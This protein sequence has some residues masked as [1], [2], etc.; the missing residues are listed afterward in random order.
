MG[1]IAKESGG[2]GFAPVNEGLHQAVAYS[3]Y[4]LGTHLIE[5]FGKHAHQILIIWE[6]PEERI[7]I[8]KDG[9]MQNLP[10]VVSKK[11]TLSLGEKANLRKDLQTWRGKAFTPDELKGFDVR[12]ILGKSCQIQVIH[13]K[14]NEKTY[15]NISA[16]MPPA[17][18]SAPLTPEN[19][20]R[21]YSIIDH[22]QTIPEGTPEW[23]T[24]IIKESDEWA[25]FHSTVS[26]DGP[27]ISDAPIDDDVPF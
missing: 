17:K 8:E 9:K 16:I 14:A 6:L 13:A 3:L 10:R 21:Y 23:I 12:N 11:Y 22:G 19:P 24:D 15:A 7:D 4:D 26:D 25:A 2:S 5:K 27:P 18:G 20:V 1:L